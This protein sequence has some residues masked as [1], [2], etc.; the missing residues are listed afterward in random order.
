MVYPNSWTF[1]VKHDGFRRTPY[2][3]DVDPMPDDILGNR[4]G[5]SGELAQGDTEEGAGYT[6]EGLRNEGRDELVLDSPHR[7][8]QAETQQHS[9]NCHITTL[10]PNNQTSSAIQTYRSF[11]GKSHQ[12]GAQSH[13]WVETEFLSKV[14]A[15]F[16]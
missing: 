4:V 16:L 3:D 1:D 15:G 8:Q 12:V 9:P 7:T 14:S 13:C 5:D 11:L 2:A 6:G 10:R